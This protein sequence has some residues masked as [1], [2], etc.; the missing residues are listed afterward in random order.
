MTERGQAVELALRI[1]E[2]S[3][4]ALERGLGLIERRL[5][6]PAVEHEQQIAGPDLLTIGYGDLDDLT[7]DPRLDRDA[8]DRLDPPDGA[9]LQ[10][11]GRAATSAASTGCG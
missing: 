4:V 6:L 2:L 7:V 5:R 9:E 8:G 1:G 11:I 10:G 3:L